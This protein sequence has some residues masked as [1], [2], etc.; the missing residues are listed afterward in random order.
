MASEESQ[1]TPPEKKRNR[2]KIGIIVGVVAAIVIVC[3]AGFAYAHEQPWFCNF[4]CHTPMD[5]ALETYAGNSGE[6]GVDKYGNVVEDAG[7]ILL[8]AHKEAAGMT[9]VSCHESVIAQ[10]ITEGLHWVPGDYEYPL[11]ERSLTALNGYGQNETPEQFCLN[12]NCHN[13]TREQLAVTT[14]SLERNPHVVEVNHREFE[15][16]DCHKVHRQSVMYCSA[17]HEDADVPEGWLSFQEAAE[18]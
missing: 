11:Q 16:S 6:P 10:Q 3:G 15:C 9:C 8:V 2:K 13:T 14:A 7:D 17:C 4:A 12:E 18:L 1:S 5:P